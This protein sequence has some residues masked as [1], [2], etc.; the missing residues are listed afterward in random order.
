MLAP[1]KL[2]AFEVPL[3][4]RTHKATSRAIFTVAPPFLSAGSREEA[5]RARF[6]GGSTRACAVL[7]SCFARGREG[8]GD[9]CY[10]VRACV[11]VCCCASVFVHDLMTLYWCVTL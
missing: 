8:G 2:R 1:M 3:I 9:P 7:M 5:V 11:L 6:A 4:N 10:A